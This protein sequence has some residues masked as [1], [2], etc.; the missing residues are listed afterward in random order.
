METTGCI[1]VSDRRLLYGLAKVLECSSLFTA[2]GCKVVVAGL[3][4]N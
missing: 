4:F 2:Q 1:I 3:G